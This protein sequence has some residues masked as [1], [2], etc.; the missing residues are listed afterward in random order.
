MA[1]RTL[2]IKRIDPWSVLKVGFLA[3]LV[4]LGILL[5]A[6]R[7]VW[8]FI[9]R[10]ELIDRACEVASSVG[11]QNCG[12]NGG[13]IFRNAL[14]LGLLGVV[15]Q[16]GILVFG[17]FLHNL[18]A[19]LTGGLSMTVVDDGPEHRAAATVPPASGRVPAR[20][21]AGRRHD[22]LHRPRPRRDR[23]PPRRPVRRRAGPGRPG[24]D[25]RLRAPPRARRPARGR[26]RP[27]S[28]PR[29]APRRSSRRRPRRPCSAR[30]APAGTCSAPSEAGPDRL[31]RSSRALVGG[32]RTSVAF[33]SRRAPVGA[34]HPSGH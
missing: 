28:P 10:L 21:G 22:R 27:A 1:R 26:R 24:P 32:P 7:V 17:T 3:N 31:W 30:A 33:A 9:E 2:T 19:E 20:P 34:T 11:F 23:R 4:L 25:R 12:L 5:L 13:N 8:F 6:G 15:V 16:T 18:I 14:L 29:R